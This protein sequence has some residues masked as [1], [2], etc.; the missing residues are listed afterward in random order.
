MK[1]V[2]WLWK[3]VVVLES[4]T[5]TDNAMVQHIR[6]KYWDVYHLMVYESRKVFGLDI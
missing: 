5:G 2:P 1:E 6:S 3:Y 4:S